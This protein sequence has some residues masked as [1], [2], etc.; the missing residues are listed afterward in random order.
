MTKRPEV[1]DTVV[2]RGVV[3]GPSSYNE[4][5]FLVKL[6]TDV[7]TYL[8]IKHIT[9][10]IP[11]PWEPKVGDKIRHKDGGQIY[12]I[13]ALVDDQAWFAYKNGD[14]VVSFYPEKYNL[15]AD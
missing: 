11:K 1:G 9:E 12:T 8:S 7:K 2:T 13:K 3:I 6:G 4:D 5:V 10:V 15:C 14:T